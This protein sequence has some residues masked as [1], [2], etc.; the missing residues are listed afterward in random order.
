MDFRYQAAIARTFGRFVEK[1][2]VYK[3][4]KPVHWCI[5]CRTALPRP[6]SSPGSRVVVHLRRVSAGAGESERTRCARA[7]PRRPQCLGPHLDDD[8]LDDSVEPGRRVSSGVRL[9]RLRRGRPG[10]DCRRG[11]GADGRGRRSAGP[12][13]RSVAKHEGREFEGVRFRHPFYD[14]DSL[15]VLGE[16]VTLDAGTGA[17][18][19]RPATVPTISIP[20]RNTGSRSSAGRTGRTFSRHRRAVRRPACVRCEPEGRGGAQGARPA[21][22]SCVDFSHQYPHCWRCHNPGHFPRNVSVVH[23]A[24]RS[25]PEGGHRTRTLR[26]RRSTPSTAMSSGFRH[27]A[28]TGFTTWSRTARTGAS[29]GSVSGACPFPPSTARRCG[30]AI[31][32]GRNWSGGTAQIFETH[33]ADAWYERP[34]EDFRPAM[35]CHARSAETRRFER[36]M[37]ILD[38]LVRLGIQPR[39]GALGPPGAV[40]A[41][42]PLPRRQRSAPRLVS[43]LPARRAS[44][45]AAA[46]RSVR[47]SPTDS[48]STMMAGRCRSR[49]ES[50][51]SPKRSSRRAAPTSCVSGWR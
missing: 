42:R 27:G 48:S 40:L 13:I 25:P 45:R 9:R 38:C 12:S 23:P 33:G 5:H 34:V 19:R 21:V 46:L 31:H 26:R 3:G 17:C 50:R 20:A 30:E 39:S 36:E 29:R 49:S 8:A 15:G 24:G 41:G 35:A 11:A 1:G 16:Y 44:A 47:S 10:R 22:A 7:G 2:L 37:N 28:T 51:S 14:R 6:R 18:I 4:K 43:E 32:I